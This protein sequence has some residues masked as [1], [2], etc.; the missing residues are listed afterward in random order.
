MKKAAEQGKP[1]KPRPLGWMAVLLIMSAP[2]AA[3]DFSDPFRVMPGD[4]ATNS[5]V[6]QSTPLRPIPA[7]TLTTRAK[8]DHDYSLAE[9]SALALQNNPQTAAGWANV[10][11]AS[12]AV[13]SAEAAWLP[14]LS[15]SVNATQSQSTTSTGFSIPQQRVLSP[16]LSLS[17]LLWDF[18]QRDAAL[19]SAKA[20]TAVARFNQNQTVQ[21]VLQNV[22]VAYYQSLADRVLIKVNEQSVANAQ[23]AL[24]AA[25]AR[26]R[27]GQATVS[28]LYQAKAALAQAEST[29]ATARQTRIQNLGTLA[30]AVGWPVDTVINL[31]P[32]DAVA[33]PSL[34]QNVQQL[35][36]DAVVRNPALQAADANVAAAHAGVE[37]AERANWPTISLSANQGLRYQ[38]GQGQ[39]Q[40]N[41]IGLSLSV[42]IFTGFANQYQTL[43]AQAKLA[44]ALA[45]RDVTYQAT[46][47]AVWQ[48]Y[49]SFQGAVAGIPG[50]RAQVENATEA[51]KAV[52]A[53]YQVGYATIQDLLTAQNTQ[54]SAEVTLAQNALNAYSALAKL[55]AAIG[56]LDSTDHHQTALPDPVQPPVDAASTMPL[57]PPPSAPLP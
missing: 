11:A 6:V 56:T 21:T 48:A 8:A 13:G 20:N 2:A 54:A 5:K 43:A 49:Y 23:R 19:A 9:L 26:Y 53:Q 42:P 15:A 30:Q 28:D 50:A 47:L 1:P 33:L 38:Q 27:S 14:R 45:T 36:R 12:A 10:Q 17:W 24:D 52:Q 44:N 25:Q 40:T 34:Q 46:T 7:P 31:A 37:Q 57:L 18:G 35:L 55:G 16:N 41:S 39:A 32:L 4:M 51:L 22:A 29:L 3:R